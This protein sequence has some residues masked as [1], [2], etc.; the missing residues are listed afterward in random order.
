M[1]SLAAAILWLGLKPSTLFRMTSY[2][3]STTVS[4]SRSLGSD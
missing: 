3:K 2:R 4:P 1:S